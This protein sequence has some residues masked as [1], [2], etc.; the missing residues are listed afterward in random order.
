MADQSIV[1]RYRGKNSSHGVTKQTARKLAS[2]LGL[3]EIQ[4]IHEALAKFAMEHLPAYEPDDGPLSKEV[5]S[6]IRRAEPK[7]RGKVISS[8]F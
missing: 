4:V 2:V 3:S 6:A 5:M 8:L 1:F 7:K